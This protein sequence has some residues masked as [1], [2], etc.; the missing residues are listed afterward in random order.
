MSLNKNWTRDQ[1]LVAFNL[2]C[3]IPFGKIHS[4]NPLLIKYSGL[5]GRTPSALSMKLANIASLDLEITSTGRKGL[6]GA[7]VADKAMWDEM[8]SD[9][10]NF[11]IKSEKAIADVE[12]E[13]EQQEDKDI[14]QQVNDQE[15]IDYI[16]NTKM[17]TTKARVGQAFFRKAVLSA[18]DYKCCITVVLY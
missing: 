10:E 2:Y 11:A 6:Q 4:R 9:W 1:L 7:S 5:I 16:G 18:Y 8:Q 13:N 15:Q 3:Q 14:S 17:V 12:I